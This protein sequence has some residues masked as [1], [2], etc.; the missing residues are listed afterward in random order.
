MI[1]V[2]D[3]NSYLGA[4][5]TVSIKVSN[6]G[7][8]T[9]TA[10]QTVGVVTT[11]IIYAITNGASFANPIGGATVS[12]YEIISIFGANFDATGGVGS[13]SV[14]QQGSTAT[15][16]YVFAS[17]MNNSVSGAS[18]VVTVT[19]CLGSTSAS[20]CSAAAAATPPTAGVFLANAPL[21]FVSNNQIN[22]IVP[23]E[24]QGIPAS[25]VYGTTYLGTNSAS[26]GASVIV[27]VGTASTDTAFLLNTSAA[28]PGVFTPGGSGE[29]NAAVLIG[30]NYTLNSPTNPSTV[31]S[32]TTTMHI[33][34][35]RLGRPDRN[36]CRD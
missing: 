4:A 15:A 12:P 1:V 2:L 9:F 5:T 30:N 36:K 18:G 34:L 24:I 35:N 14:E 28:T 11:P 29:G 8:N 6:D 16:P 33:F 32:T 20:A 10:P 7:G 19:F 25:G 3:H 23:T 27:T 31:G 17:S 22:A 21:I 13:S 26:T